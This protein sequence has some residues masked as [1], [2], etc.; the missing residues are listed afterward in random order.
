MSDFLAV[1]QKGS[2]SDYYR[3]QMLAKCFESFSFASLNCAR[4]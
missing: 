1:G 4:R 3:S 2:D